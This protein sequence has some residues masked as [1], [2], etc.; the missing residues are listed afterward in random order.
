MQLK[1]LTNHKVVYDG[2]DFVWMVRLDSS[3]IRHYV[4]SFVEYNK[5]MSWIHHNIYIWNKEYRDRQAEYLANMRKKLEIDVRITEISREANV[6]T[7]QKVLE[8]INLRPDIS[9]KAIAELLDI[10]IRSVE[11]H[12]K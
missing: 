3:W 7:K 12:R 11:R 9:N 1:E 4:G 6:K 8:I 10:T 5:P 2:Y